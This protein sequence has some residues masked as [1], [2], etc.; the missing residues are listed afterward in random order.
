[1]DLRLS[2]KVFVVTGASAGIGA[3][4]VALLAAEGATA[5]GVSRK[6]PESATA[7]DGILADLTEPAAARRIVDE[8]VDRYG[9]LDGVV[10]NVGGLDSRSGFLDVTDEQWLATF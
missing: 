5:V 1:M 6:P 8:V 7:V 4:T 10:N 9:T 2:G 3:S